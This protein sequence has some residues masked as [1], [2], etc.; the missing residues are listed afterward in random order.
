MI[1]R[2][3]R[4]T[5]RYPASKHKRNKQKGKRKKQLS[6]PGSVIIS[7]CC[8]WLFNWILVI[9]TQVIILSWYLLANWDICQLFPPAV[10][11]LPSSNMK[12]N[13]II[14]QASTSVSAW[15]FCVLWHMHVVS[16]AKGFDPQFCGGFRLRQ[17]FLGVRMY[18]K[19]PLWI[20]NSRGYIPH[21]VISFLLDKLWHLAEAL[22]LPLHTIFKGTCT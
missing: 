9:P 21:W 15:F 19:P 1:S 13:N 16:S 2:K 6:S 12:A 18:L 10:H 8:N 11:T 20:N 14:Q 17:E 7:T 4:A 22:L 3:V 5:Q